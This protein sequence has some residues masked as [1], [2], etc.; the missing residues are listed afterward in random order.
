MK[1]FKTQV[2]FISACLCA[3]AGVIDF[4]SPEWI[5]ATGSSVF[6]VN[7]VTVTAGDETPIIGRYQKPTLNVGSSGIGI[8]TKLDLNANEISSYETATMSFADPNGVD[9]D[10]I[11][12]NQLFPR[13]S[14][15][16]PA[17]NGRYRVDG[18][19]WVTFTGVNDN[20]E[21]VLND[22]LIGVHTL[23]FSIPRTVVDLAASDY[24]VRSI[25]TV[26][27]PG[28]FGLLGL[29]IGGCVVRKRLTA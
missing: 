17:E 10:Q 20:G 13:Q 23:T 4:S 2:L 16:V 27:E 8:R 22:R 1:S 9:I 28:T 18:G 3:G 7:Y 21:L 12:I 5:A 15:L 11:V 14:P 6:T 29:G 19:A 25:E 24:T 26:T